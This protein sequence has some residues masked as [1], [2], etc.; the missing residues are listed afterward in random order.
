MALGNQGIFYNDIRMDNFDNVSKRNNKMI[1]NET[2]AEIVTNVLLI[3]T[4]SLMIIV[5]ILRGE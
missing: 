3:V 4:L 2:K 1:D 5:L